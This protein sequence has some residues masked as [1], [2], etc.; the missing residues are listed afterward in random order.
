MKKLKIKPGKELKIKTSDQRAI[1]P[2][3]A[4]YWDENMDG[5]DGTTRRCA[6]STDEEPARWPDVAT[7]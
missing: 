7:K 2:V 5:A 6:A 1:D 3:E 4:L